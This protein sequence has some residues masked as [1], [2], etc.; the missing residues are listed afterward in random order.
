MNKYHLNVYIIYHHK[1]HQI[2]SIHHYKLLHY[3]Y[4]V[5]VDMNYFIMFLS[6]IFN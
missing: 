5:E 2:L 4:Q 3:D 6:K 1:I